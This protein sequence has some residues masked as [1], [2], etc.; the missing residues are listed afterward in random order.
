MHPLIQIPNAFPECINLQCVYSDA[1]KPWPLYWRYAT[2]Q[3]LRKSTKTK[4]VMSCPLYFLK[5]KGYFL[6]DQLYSKNLQEDSSH[7]IIHRLFG[8]PSTPIH[9]GTKVFWTCNWF[10]MTG[11]PIYVW[12]GCVVVWIFWLD[13]Q[14]QLRRPCDQIL[15]PGRL[16][17]CL[18]CFF[19]FSYNL[20]LKKKFS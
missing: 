3:K 9:N 1:P 12:P 10:L 2:H 14:R 7:S 11:M 6:L 15:M 20:E 18:H 5:G 17:P 16:T 4:S 19:F 13:N 8:T